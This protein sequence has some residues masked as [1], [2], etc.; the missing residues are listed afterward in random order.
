[1]RQAVSSKIR[2][3]VAARA[4]NRCEYCRF[5]EDDMF[6]AFEID[7]IISL[8]HGGDNHIDNLAHAC[9]HCNQHKG[10]DLTTFIDNYLST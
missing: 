3:A 10:T 9:P 8:K 6:V 2:L 7:H 4:K 5:H 1:M